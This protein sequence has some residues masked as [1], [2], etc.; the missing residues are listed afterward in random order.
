M[1][2]QPPAFPEL[3]QMMATL[4]KNFVAAGVFSFFI[5]MLM[6]APTIYMLQIYD[7]VLQSRNETTLWMLTL[8]VLGL[9]ALMAILEWVRSR[10]LVRAGI[11]MEETLNERVFT[12]AFEANLR[13]AGNNPGQALQDLTSLRQFLTGAGLFAFFDAPWAPIF[14]AFTFFLH[15]MLGWF[16]LGGALL[17]ILLT[18]ATEAATRKP[19]AEAGTVA[20]KSS[21]FANSSLANDE[22]IEAM[23]MMGALRARWRKN[24]NKHLALQALASDRAGI[25]SSM[26]RFVRMSMQSLILGLGAYFTLHGEISPGAMIAGSILMGRSLAPVEQ[27]IANWRNFVATRSAYGRLGELLQ[28]FPP[29]RDSMSLPAPQGEILVEGLV[30]VPPGSQTVVLKGIGMAIAPGEVVAIIG[31][32]ASGKSTL[33]RMLVGIWPPHA[34]KVR[35]DGADVYLWDKEK[36]GPHIGYLPQDI[37]LFDGTIA[38][39]IARFGEIDADKVIAAATRA[40]V[41]EMILRF[42]L[43]Y[44]SPIGVGGGALSGGQKQRIGLARALYGDPALI[45]LDEPNSNLD[46]QGEAALVQSVLELKAQGKTVVIITHRTNI[47]SVVDRILVLRDGQVQLYGPRQEVLEAL[48]RAAQQS[49]PGNAAAL[50]SPAAPTLAAGRPA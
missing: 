17:L 25:I 49:R 46:D 37:E 33:A 19:L 34:G 35:L 7:R 36:L 10:L 41:H 21:A 32:S 31:P 18:L 1:A 28:R 26:T 2:K 4:R 20:I 3:N 38:E 6:L 45:V 43:G 44:D 47:I 50:G 24:H 9:F 15:P 30:A 16:A 29:R 5:N 48:A 12:A 40:G 11:R 27:L 13:K 8:L 39:N 23:G 42:P 22:V 14:L